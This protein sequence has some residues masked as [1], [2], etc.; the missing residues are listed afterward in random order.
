MPDST[1]P[2]A[3]LSAADADRF[4]ITAN[5]QA[6]SA[7]FVSGLAHE[8]NNPLQV[9]A[10]T[11]ELLLARQDLPPDVV[12]K[13][14]RVAAQTTRASQTIMEVLGF[15]RD[16]TPAPVKADLRGL[17]DQAIALRRYPMNRAGIQVTLEAPDAGAATLVVKPADVLQILIN[18]IM[19]AEAALAGQKGGTIAITVTVDGR[20]AR[21]RVA[22]NGPGIAPEV[23]DRLF[24]P[25]VTRHG[26]DSAGGLG[27]PASRALAA[28]YGGRLTHEPSDTG[29]AFVLEL[30]L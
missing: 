22:D 5:R 28:R 19:N 24:D 13:L 14:E 21:L 9:V 30:P 8:L 3:P 29:A 6:L 17:V 4:H 23:G 7:A 16:R 10:G 11:V 27:L 1:A 20:V 12:T 25:Y 18:L 2:A 15:V 26:L